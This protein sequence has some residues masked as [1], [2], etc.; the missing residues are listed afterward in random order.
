MDEGF[1]AGVAADDDVGM[2]YRGA[3]LA[4]VVTVRDGAQAFRV[5][6]GSE[7]PIPARLL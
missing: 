2:H 4:E 6:P 7:T 1:P 3:E 5:E